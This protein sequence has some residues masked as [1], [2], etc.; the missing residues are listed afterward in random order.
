[1]S[2]AGDEPGNYT[3][4]Y[5]EDHFGL[6]KNTSLDK[7]KG[8]INSPTP[9]GVVT[10]R[11]LL[12]DQTTDVKK[13]HRYQ[14]ATKVV[15]LERKSG[16]VAPPLDVDI[17]TQ[18]AGSESSPVS[19][20]EQVLRLTA[21]LAPIN[22]SEVITDR[23]WIAYTLEKAGIKS[24]KF[25]QP[26]NTSLK[27][28]VEGAV[29]S[30][31]TLKM[32]AGFVR[33]LGNNW[34]SNSSLVQGDFRSFYQARYLGAMRGYLGATIA[35]CVYPSYVPSSAVA[36]IPDI[37]IGPR[38]AIVMSFSGKPQLKPT[39]FWSVSLYGQDQLFIENELQQYALGDRS[40]LKTCNGSQLTPQNDGPFNILLQP[41]DVC[42]PENW[43]S[44]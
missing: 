43:K 30:A 18:V 34:Y 21:A 12:L 24:G 3:L 32:T 19:E 13:V 17:F 6:H 26:A 36:E 41:A 14:D 7:D 29:R 20:E 16:P 8:Y 37:N 25:I 33:D 23:G 31:R 42:P 38:Q 35:Q 2:T 22:L 1:M 4:T 9:Y 5:S 28:A 15:C 11:F 27:L 44:K 39:G 10:T 40:K